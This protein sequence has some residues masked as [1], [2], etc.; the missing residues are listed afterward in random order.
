MAQNCWSVVA[1]EDHLANDPITLAPFHSL[2]PPDQTETN[3]CRIKVL[4]LQMVQGLVARAAS[5]EQVIGPT[6]ILLRPF[7][8][9]LELETAHKE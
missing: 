7:L 5:G 1:P 9:L 6:W 2:S 3:A 4:S 8:I